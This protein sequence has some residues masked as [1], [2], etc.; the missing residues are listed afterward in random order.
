MY[1]QVH[2][3]WIIKIDNAGHY[4]KLLP[5]TILIRLKRT[6]GRENTIKGDSIYLDWNLLNACCTDWWVHLAPKSYYKCHFA[7][8][9]SVRIDESPKRDYQKRKNSFSTPK[10]QPIKILTLYC[11][12]W[13]F[14]AC[15]CDDF[16][17]KSNVQ[18]IFFLI[19][20]KCSQTLRKN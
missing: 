3:I 12:R 14:H 8:Q 17:V 6:D 4:R 11:I 20:N 7:A 19:L 13:H 18:I 9:I 1:I 15:F 5:H 10:R 16:C 2:N